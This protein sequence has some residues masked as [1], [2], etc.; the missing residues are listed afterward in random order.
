MRAESWN[1]KLQAI[2]GRTLTATSMNWWMDGDEFD[3]EVGHSP[4]LYVFRKMADIV[5]QS[6]SQAFVFV[7]EHEDSIT[8]GNFICGEGW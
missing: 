3:G 8:R 5:T 4:Y 1:W 6:P 2:Y 7:D